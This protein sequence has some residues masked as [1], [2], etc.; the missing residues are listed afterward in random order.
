MNKKSHY[1]LMTD[2]ILL[3]LVFGALYPTTALA[4]GGVTPPTG[5]AP[6]RQIPNSSSSSNSLSQ[7]PS[8]TKVMIVDSNG[9]KVPLGSQ[10]SADILQ[11]GDPIFCVDTATIIAASAPGCSPSFT[12]LSALVGYL[13]SHQPTSDGTI[14]IEQGFQGSS[15]LIVRITGSVATT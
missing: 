7:V 12:V 13:A 4:D 10:Q 6:S 14:W 2:D 5:T 9:N 1:L 8:G 11:S 3:V 15:A